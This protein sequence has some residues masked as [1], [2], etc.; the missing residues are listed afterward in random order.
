M[1]ETGGAS[2]ALPAR[3]GT[4]PGW[5]V[6]FEGGDGAGKTTQVR[7]LTDELE[8]RGHPVL[9]TREPGGTRLGEQIRDL[10]LHGGHVAPRAEALL[11][12]ADK[13]HHVD[14]VVRPGLAAGQVVVTDRYT[15]SSIAYQGMGRGLGRDEIRRLLHWAVRGLLPDLTIVL[16]VTPETG[17]LRRGPVHD[18]LEAE[19]DE[20]HAVVR[21][22]FLDLAARDPAR[23]LVLDAA[24]P[25]EEIARQVLG[26]LEA[27]WA[28]AAHASAG[29]R[30]SRL[31]G[32]PTSGERA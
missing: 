8:R 31:G 29:G 11:Y 28:A 14:Q 30:R 10:L 4:A 7:L 26:R 18:R 2:G 23:Y 21:Q 15:D 17:R 3:R 16:D 27:V 5:F 12:A 13:A 24:N 1:D 25:P 20:F 9:V 22:G 19:A 32:I 6:C